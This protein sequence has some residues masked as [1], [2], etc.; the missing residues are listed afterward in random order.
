LGVAERA[1]EVA[2]IATRLAPITNPKMSSDL[3][4]AI[5]LAKAA[6]EGALANVEINLASLQPGTP[7]DEAFASETRK[8]AVGLKAQA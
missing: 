7:E 2:Q 3:I 4:T 8:R 1:A 6:L 5:A